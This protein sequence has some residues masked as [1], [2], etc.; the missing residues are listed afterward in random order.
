[1]KVTDFSKYTTDF[2]MKYL[3]LERGASNNTIS[4]YRDTFVLLSTFMEDKRGIKLKKLMLSDIT[5]DVIIEF[6]NWL[7][8]DRKCS[9]STRNQRLAVIRSFF[10]Y[11]QY[12]NPE[13]MYECHRIM[14]I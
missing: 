1:M 8:E 6:L 14:S 13:F 2:F 12:R 9:G 10:S 11:V 7:Q 4:S 3:A 5:Q